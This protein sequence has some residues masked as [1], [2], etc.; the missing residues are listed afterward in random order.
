MTTSF[1]QFIEHLFG[2][3][4]VTV[5]RTLHLM[6]LIVLA[7]CWSLPVVFHYLRLA[8]VSWGALWVP[9]WLCRKC[10]HYSPPDY[11][12][13]RQ[14]KAPMTTAWWEKY[15]PGFFADSARHGGRFLLFWYRIAGLVV[16]YVGTLLAFWTL[17]FYSFA[18]YPL[19]ELMAVLAVVTLLLTM[20]FGG[21]ALGAQKGSI[22]ARGM[23]LVA[24]A[25]MAALT[26]LWLFLWAAAPFPP[27]K[28]L[29]YVQALTGGRVHLMTPG[30]LQASADGNLADGGT[31]F[32]IQYAV[33]RWPLFHI[34][35]PF[36]TRLVSE[37]VLDP[38]TLLT[39]DAAASVFRREDPYR[40]RVLLQ[41]RSFR[42]EPGRTYSLREPSEGADWLL[43]ETSK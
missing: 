14:C 12:E 31:R 30:G 35:Q 43:E 9:M 22:V 8:Q 24:G 6:A 38:W 1:L 25:G 3:Q 42:V 13:C 26:G 28:P 23:D 36:V 2:D 19:Q 40:P 17:R 21:R 34:H 16:F 41:S 37:P 11:V 18:Q 5:S 39:F 7:A 32:S 29:A 20:G 10:G 15:L 33:V 27:G 4:L